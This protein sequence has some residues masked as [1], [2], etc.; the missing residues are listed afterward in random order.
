MTSKNYK[1]S[2]PPKDKGDSPLFRVVYSIDVGAADALKAAETGYLNWSRYYVFLVDRKVRET[3]AEAMA[4]V[5]CHGTYRI[6]K[7]LE[8]R[9]VAVII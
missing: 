3:E 2:P 8:L 9:S 4:F 1:I 5:I 6:W 7:I